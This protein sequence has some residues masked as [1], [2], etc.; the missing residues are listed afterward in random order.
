VSPGAGEVGAVL[1]AAD[2][3]YSG[4]DDKEIGLDDMASGWTLD[5]G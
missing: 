2:D 5:A 1:A 4:G 3:M